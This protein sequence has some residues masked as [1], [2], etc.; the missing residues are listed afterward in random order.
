[1]AKVNKIGIAKLK[2]AGTHVGKGGVRGPHFSSGMLDL[3]VGSGWSSS[4]GMLSPNRFEC[5][6]KSAVLMIT[7]N[8][9]I[10]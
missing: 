1:M 7:S 8:V 6:P 10:Q 3:S 2:T 4:A 5:T 9:P